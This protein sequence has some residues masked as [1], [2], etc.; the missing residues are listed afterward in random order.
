[1]SLVYS[2]PQ[3]VAIQPRLPTHRSFG[4]LPLRPTATMRRTSG[5]V[6]FSRGGKSIGGVRVIGG[7]GVI[8]GIRVIGV[9]GGD[10]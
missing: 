7:I 2:D 10:D 6:L 9:V 5:E 3:G 8:G 1:M 4:A